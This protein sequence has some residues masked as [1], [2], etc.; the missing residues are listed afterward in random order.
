MRGA[1]IATLV[2]I[3]KILNIKSQDYLSTKTIQR[4]NAVTVIRITGTARLQ[5]VVNV[6][7]KIYIIRKVNRGQF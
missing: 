5:Y 6:M 7:M 1:R 3:R 2:G 4:L